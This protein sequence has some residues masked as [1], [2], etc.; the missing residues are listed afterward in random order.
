[1]AY[2]VAYVMNRKSKH[3]EAAWTFI[4]YL[5]SKQGM[6]TWA[7]QGLALPSRRSVLAELG[8]DQNP[9]YAPFAKGATYATIWQGKDTLPTLFT[10]F[11]NQF[12]SALLGEQSLPSAMQKAQD[13]ANREIYLAN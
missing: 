6:K 3:K 7:Q 10:N 9:L 1:M 11:N 4:A 2:T 5:T 13:T 8:Y 12:V